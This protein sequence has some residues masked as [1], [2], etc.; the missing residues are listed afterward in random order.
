[1]F[2]NL[3]NYNQIRMDLDVFHSVLVFIVVLLGATLG[4]LYANSYYYARDGLLI[5]TMLMRSHTEIYHYHESYLSF[6]RMI[7][8]DIQYIVHACIYIYI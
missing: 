6:V 7:S 2:L 1:M 3:L 5:H 4:E 8:S